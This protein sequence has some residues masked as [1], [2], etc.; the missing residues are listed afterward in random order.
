MLSAAGG[1]VSGAGDSSGAPA[2]AH[3]AASPKISAAASARAI[4]VLGLWAMRRTRSRTLRLPPVM[5][6]ADWSREV[7]PA[8]IMPTRV[9]P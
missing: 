9:R 4:A 3:P 5:V 2:K 6:V 8:A 1:V 7:R